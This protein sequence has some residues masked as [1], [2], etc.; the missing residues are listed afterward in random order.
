MAKRTIVSGINQTIMAA[1]SMVTIAALIDA[2]GLGQTVAGGA[3][4]PRRRH[5]LQRRPGHRHHGDRARPGDHRGQRRVRAARAAPA[6]RHRAAGDRRRWPSAR[7]VTAVCVYLSLHLSCGRRS[8][9]A[10]RRD[11]G[12]ADRS[13]AGDSVTD[14][15]AGAPRSTSPS[16]LKDTV[17]YALLNPL[18]ALL[19][20]SPWW[21]VGAAIVAAGLPARRL[22]RGRHRGRLPGAASSRIGL[23]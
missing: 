1:L 10:R 21:L 18:Q 4:D 3:A 11:L 19:A 13:D 5:R 2:P 14:W 22:A 8:S 9:P 12:S 20:D 17:T 16:A 15:V 6:P 7:R 23:W